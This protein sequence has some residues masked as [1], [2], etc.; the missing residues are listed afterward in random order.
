LISWFNVLALVQHHGHADGVTVMDQG[1]F[2]AMWSLGFGG[3]RLDPV[4]MANRLGGNLPTPHLAI[5]VEASLPTIER[6]LAERPVLSRL[7][8]QTA[9]DARRDDQ[10]MARALKLYEAVKKAAMTVAEQ[11]QNMQLYVVDNDQEDE[12]DV[13]IS[14]IADLVQAM[15]S[16]DHAGQ[17]YAD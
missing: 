6:R 7:Q 3:W 11:R 10:L 4:R 16:E 8:E 14:R 12:I 2:Q 9:G 15:W 1:V 17:P 13:S 5:A